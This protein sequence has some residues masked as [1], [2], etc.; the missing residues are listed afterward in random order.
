VIK[1][2]SQKL[3]VIALHYNKMGY[4]NASSYIIQRLYKKH[5]LLSARIKNT[6]LVIYLRNDPYDTQVFTQIFMRGELD[7]TFRKEPGYVIDGGANIGLAALYLK[8]KYPR[9]KIIAVEP[10]RSNFELLKK[11][12]RDYPDIICLNYGIW[13]KSGRLRIIDNGDGNASFITKDMSEI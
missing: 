9:A 1:S 5:K 3:K 7:I 2:L 6:K 10:E 8:N 13:N 12:T 11:N 4:A